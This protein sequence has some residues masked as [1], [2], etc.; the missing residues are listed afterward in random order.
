MDQNDD[1]CGS[2][3]RLVR[4]GRSP[5]VDIRPV[6]LRV[7]VDM[8]V[9]R[10]HHAPADLVQFDDMIGRLLDDSD[11]DVRRSVAEKLARHPATPRR[12]LDRFLAEGGDIAAVVLAGA[13][14][15]PDILQRAADWG[16]TAMAIAVA[17]RADLSPAMVASLIDR[18]EPQVLLALAENAA[19][20]I[21]REPY[22]YLVRRARDD[23]DLGRALLR[24]PGLEAEQAP[25][26]LMADSA[27]RSAI[28]LA[29]RREDLGPGVARLRLSD[30]EAAALA[31]VESAVIAPDRDGFDGALAL[32]LHIDRDEVRRLIDDERGEPLALALAAVGAS[33]DLAARV[34]IL[35]GPA[36]GHSVMAVR[37]L[38]ALVDGIPRRTAARLVAAMTQPTW[39]VPRRSAEEES[40]TRRRGEEGRSVARPR[41]RAE[42]IVAAAQRRLRGV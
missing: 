27:Q 17:G 23:E 36:I 9:R 5:N 32:A 15:D 31:R 8:F 22:R 21:G 7:L 26:F 20:P 35:S 16:T 42:E 28:V 34:F 10:Q 13:T 39:R 37:R 29:A 2:L 33:A 6:L 41:E 25:L 38:T 12:L 24:R 14:V 30:D 4:L 11:A 3:E 1:L 18:P 19:A 40:E